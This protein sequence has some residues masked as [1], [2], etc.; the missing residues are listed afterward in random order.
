MKP[1]RIAWRPGSFLAGLSR[2]SVAAVLVLSVV[3]G[4]LGGAL[5]SLVDGLPWGTHA[6]AGVA[7]PRS[8]QLVP[9]PTSSPHTL[10]DLDCTSAIEAMCI[11]DDTRG[12]T[13]TGN[14]S[15]YSCTTNDY[16][17]AAET[18]YD[19]F[20]DGDWFEI[21]LT[22]D[23]VSGANDL[24]LFLLEDCDENACIHSSLGVEGVEE[25]CAGYLYGQY[26]LVVDGY[27][28]QQDGSDFT[29][30]IRCSGALW[31][32]AGNGY[33]GQVGIPVNLTAEAEGHG[34]SIVE[35]L[36][37]FGDG[38][39]ASTAQPEI[40]HTYDAASTYLVT[41]TVT[42]DFCD[43]RTAADTTQV[44]VVPVAVDPASWGQVKRL[45]H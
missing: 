32:N 29:L 8:K 25:I 17:D 35:Y 7:L 31:C 10:A 20:C 45:H 40:S 42:D 37:E 22:Y 12:V 41:L 9:A 18:V 36:W 15:R 6:W 30:T 27:Q 44:E 21:E 23:H 3:A 43:P 34:T 4:A 24:D 38:A 11:F 2:L 1:S 5:V 33:L 19:L 13:G 26:Y 16:S 39:T 28:G 14:V